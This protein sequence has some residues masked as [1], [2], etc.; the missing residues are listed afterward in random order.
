MKF[1][2]NTKRQPLVYEKELVKYWKENQIFEKSVEFRSENNRYVFYDG[3]PFITGVPHYGNLLSCIV[4]DT[5]P[6]Y[7]T[8]KGK[9]VERVWGWDC[10]GLPA[11][12]FTEQKLG[13]KDKRDIGTKVSL[14]EYINTCRTNMVQT[15]NEWEEI[16]DRI[17]RWVDFRGAYKTMD[18]DYM[19]SVWWAFKELHSAGKIYEG[20]KVLLYC[21]RDAT[22]ISKAEVAMDN[23]YKE[24]T[25][26]SVYVKFP[27]EGENY[28]LLAWTT[29]PWTLLAN[30]AIAVNK[31]LDY[32]LIKVD[33]DNLV[34]AEELLSKVLLDNE[35]KPLKYKVLKKIKGSE[36]LGKKYKPLFNNR[37]QNAHKIWHADYISTDEGTG[38]VHIAPAYG[39][40]DFQL[41]KENDIPII[42]VL[43][44]NGLFTEGKWQ[45]INV[46]ESNKNIAK[47]LINQNIIWKVHYYQHSYPHCHRCGTRLMYRAHPSWFL[48]VS[49]EKQLMLE[50]NSNIYW[51]PEHIKNGRFANTVASAPDWN[52]SRDR[53]WA[54]AMPVWKGFDEQGNAYTKVVGSYSELE[55]LS[56]KV[57]EDYHRPWI[58]DITFN[59]DGIEYKRIDKVLDC[60]FESGSMPFAQFH[61]PFENVDKFE[62][63]FP[64]DFISEYVGQVR[65]WFYYLHAVSV[66]LFRK[67]SFKNVIVTGTLA[68]NDGRKMSK[69]F[70]NF[71][72]PNELLDK[73]SADSLRLLLLGSPVL[74]G[75]DFSLQDKE[76]ADT[77]RKLNMIWNI[78]DFFSLYAEVDKW[79]SGLKIGDIPEDPTSILTNQLDI[80]IVSRIHQL[81]DEVSAN[82]DKYD[83]A[84]AV[85]PLIPFIDDASNWYVRRSRKRFWKSTNDK[86][87]KDAYKTLHYVLLRLSILMGPFTPFLSEELY[88]LLTNGQ[89][90]HLLNWPST[91]MINEMVINKMSFIRDVITIGLAQRAAQGIKVRQP[92]PSVTIKGAPLYIDDI[93]EDYIN[94]I[95]EELNVKEVQYNTTGNKQTITL[96]TLIT[97]VLES[98]GLMREVIRFI[99]QD[100]K[101]NKFEVD[102]RI[103]IEIKT[104]D[105]K[106][107][108]MTD[109]EEFTEVIKRETLANSLKVHENQMLKEGYK[110]NN[111]LIQFK[112]SK[113]KK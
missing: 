80:W 48:N 17:G 101:L 21:T 108:L 94:I 13:I 102:D 56:G 10:H 107:I 100:R 14:E 7:W 53:F 6:R 113:Q 40:D 97:P 96:D 86:D 65:A 61:Y 69:S 63:N 30:T 43:D 12:V 34:I 81:T 23:S 25:D 50:Q 45:G 29:T 20:E 66:T 64:G 11:E 70:G 16:I 78:Y 109:N 2:K 67:N 41:A 77:F 85:K 59:I 72:D 33:Q 19:E 5:I 92:L 105:K 71:T 98:E 68:G 111:Q 57:L 99:Q 38:I 76:V 46:W 1:K 18:K 104:N 44:D 51:F 74:N 90:V 106:V 3:P 87:K 4:K 47:E 42:S 112:L 82:M 24:V 32:C 26:P 31:T 28:S 27:V 91:G 58:D 89:S 62:Q 35:N 15:G 93:E 84:N 39:E 36:L 95:K 88:M 60:W 8:M 83:I 79:E 22:P 103:N 110:I 9:R 49:D 52:I 75:E 55:K 73:Y 54:T 37:G